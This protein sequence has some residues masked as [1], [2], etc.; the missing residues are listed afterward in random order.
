MA[1]PHSRCHQLYLSATPNSLL[2]AQTGK[3][4]VLQH[5]S[6]RLGFRLR[7]FAIFYSLRGRLNRLETDIAVKITDSNI[8]TLT[9]NTNSIV[10]SSPTG[11]RTC[12]PQVPSTMMDV[13]AKGARLSSAEVLGPRMSIRRASFPPFYHPHQHLNQ[14]SSIQNPNKVPNTQQPDLP[15]QKNFQNFN[16]Q[17]QS[18]I[19]VLSLALA[20]TAA[21]NP[22]NPPPTNSCSQGQVTA[23]C[24]SINNLVGANC[25]QINGQYPLRLAV[26]ISSTADTPL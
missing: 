24:D 17:F 23:C 12:P 15:D 20:A 11:K 18:V 22:T 6:S 4:A 5:I 26:I 21:P 19:A 2:V 9:D 1:I 16:M 14:Q 10:Y 25:A 8:V 7:D 3:A 13:I